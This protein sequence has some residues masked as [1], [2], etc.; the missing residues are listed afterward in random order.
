MSTVS[1]VLVSSVQ[2]IMIVAILL[3]DSSSVIRAVLVVLVKLE[4][5]LNNDQLF[6]FQ[7]R[8]TLFY[9]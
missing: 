4:T 9:K 7:S 3:D 8:S 2:H 6:K 1:R 5:G